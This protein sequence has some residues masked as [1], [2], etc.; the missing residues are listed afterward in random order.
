MPLPPLFRK[1][2]G[3]NIAASLS[4]KQKHSDSRGGEAGGD[5]ATAV[6]G[7]V[8]VQ[9]DGHGD[10]RRRDEKKADLS[11]GHGSAPDC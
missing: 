1:G 7:A 3:G 9:G 10:D 8:V 11:L 6:E 4:Q 2:R 5:G